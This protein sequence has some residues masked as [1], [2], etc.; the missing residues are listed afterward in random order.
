[1]VKLLESFVSSERQ[2][3]IIADDIKVS[4]RPLRSR[5]ADMSCGVR[6]P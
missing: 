5:N 4:H 6:Q 2:L 1:M 3:L